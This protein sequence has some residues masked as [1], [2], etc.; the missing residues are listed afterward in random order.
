MTNTGTGAVGIS[1][2]TLTGAEASAFELTGEDL[3]RP[4]PGGQTR[5]AR[6]TVRFVPERHGR[7]DGDAARRQRRRVR[8]E[9]TPC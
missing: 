1:G 2:V 9:T 5:A 4:D 6:G 8:P 3:R 7:E